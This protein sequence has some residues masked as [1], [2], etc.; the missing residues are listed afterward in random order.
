VQFLRSEKYVHFAINCIF[1]F[2]LFGD[3]NELYLKVYQNISCITSPIVH[4]LFAFSAV[5]FIAS[6]Y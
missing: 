6:D 5:G 4:F 1:R 3:D 2:L